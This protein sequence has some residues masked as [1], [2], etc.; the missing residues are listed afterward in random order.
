VPY[1]RKGSN[2]GSYSEE[3]NPE[4]ENGIHENFNAHSRCLHKQ[5][6]KNTVIENGIILVNEKGQP[7]KVSL[8]NNFTVSATN[9][10]VHIPS[11]TSFSN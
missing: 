5:V 9:I 2:L 10:E 6:H 7:I 8:I 4:A 3:L 1:L 11:G